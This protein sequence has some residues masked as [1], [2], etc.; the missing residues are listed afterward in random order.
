MKRKTKEISTQIGRSFI[1]KACEHKIEFLIVGGTA[2]AYYGC[3]NYDK[4]N[5]LDLMINPTQNNAERIINLLNS[6]GLKCN[7]TVDDV[8]M[9]NKHIPL[10][11]FFDLD[12]LTP[13]NQIDFNTLI[14]RSEDSFIESCR[15]KII[16]LNDLILIDKIALEKERAELEKQEEK[17]EQ[18]LSD[19]SC[20]EQRAVVSRSA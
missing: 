18:L 10:K 4:V 1:C 6:Q 3:R 20:L 8:I 2:V 11:S 13:P 17:I 15:V 12:I 16:S 7:W 5:D 14:M 19:L 9:P